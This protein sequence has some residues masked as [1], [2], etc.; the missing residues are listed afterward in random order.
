METARSSSAQ[1]RRMFEDFCAAGLTPQEALSALHN[2]GFSQSDLVGL[3]QT[4]LI[5]RTRETA[6]AENSQRRACSPLRKPLRPLAGPQ[7]LI[8]TIWQQADRQPW[9]M[10]ALVVLGALSLAA[11]TAWKL[12]RAAGKAAYKFARP[13]R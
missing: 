11:L 13:G 10:L 4:K 1:V 2:D 9:K 8:G 12:A 7:F 6:T 3:V 5:S